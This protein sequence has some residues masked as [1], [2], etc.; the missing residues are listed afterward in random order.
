MIQRT[1]IEL[2]SAMEKKESIIVMIRSKLIEK[3][4]YIEVLT[5]NKGKKI[6]SKE[7]NNTFD[8]RLGEKNTILSIPYKSYIRY[9]SE[10]V[11]PLTIGKKYGLGIENLTKYPQIR[12]KTLITGVENIINI[13]SK[14][15]LKIGKKE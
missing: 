7:D 8:I 2:H 14:E 4:I 15:Y 13:R 11:L 6:S 12:E 3:E 9:I 5:G 1:L 10:I